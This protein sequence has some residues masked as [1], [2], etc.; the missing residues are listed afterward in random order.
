MGWSLSPYKALAALHGMAADAPAFQFT[1]CNSHVSASDACEE[2][3]VRGLVFWERER[4][5]TI[6]WPEVTW[7]GESHSS[8]CQRPDQ[9]YSGVSWHVYLADSKMLSNGGVSAS[10]GSLF[11]CLNVLTTRS[12][13]WLLTLISLFAVPTFL[14]V[15][16]IGMPNKLFS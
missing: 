12:Q 7:W 9:L 10:R 8:C 4:L 14:L 15:L 16:A 3:I 11:R 5:F 6:R 13:R 2:R 1:F